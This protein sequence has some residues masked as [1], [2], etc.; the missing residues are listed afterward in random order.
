MGYQMLSFQPAAS[1]GDDRRWS[2]GMS[3]VSIDDVWE[4][5]QQGMRRPVP[6]QAMQF[7]HPACNR[8]AY[9]ASSGTAGY[10]SSTR[11]AR[12]TFARGTQSCGG[13]AG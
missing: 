6:W 5:I 7:G 11:A 12:R 9:G 4:R 2:Q 8:T 3:T 1:V 13:S 10:P